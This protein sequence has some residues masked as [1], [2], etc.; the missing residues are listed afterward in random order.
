MNQDH[1]ALHRFRKLLDL[2]AQQ[3]S[4]V[5]IV[6]MVGNRRVLIENHKGVTEYEKI[7][8]IV[9]SKNGQIIVTGKDLE[10][11]QMSQHQ[12]VIIGHI[13]TVSVEGGS[14]K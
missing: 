5:P 10:I 3:I 1:K 8:I 9:L 2:S 7:R 4:G 11:Q 13:D 14:N 6:E 12:L